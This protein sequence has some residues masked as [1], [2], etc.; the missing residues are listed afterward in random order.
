ML[1]SRILIRGIVIAFLASACGGA[2][3]SRSQQPGMAQ[4]TVSVR[5]VPGVGNVYTDAQGRSLYSPVQEAMGKVLCTGPCTTIW[6]PL[7]AP[8]SGSPTKASSVM[9]TVNV[10]TRPDG[11]KQVTLNGAPLYRFFQDTRPGDVTG[12][13]LMDSFGGTSFTWRLE[14]G[15]GATNT[16]GSRGSGY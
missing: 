1:S 2:A 4:A 11:S 8:S 7:T 12:N 3:A 14:S 15:S 10:I 16:P 5:Q 6:L 13:G 9:G